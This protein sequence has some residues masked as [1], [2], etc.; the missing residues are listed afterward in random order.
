MC[1]KQLATIL[2]DPDKSAGDWRTTLGAFFSKWHISVD[3]V[4]VVIK[5]FSNHGLEEALKRQGFIVIPCLVYGL[6]VWIKHYSCIFCLAIT[7]R[8][9]YYSF[10]GTMYKVLL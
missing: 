9:C 3:R 7:Y 1:V 8:S 5:A 6:Q 10:L 4:K 2:C